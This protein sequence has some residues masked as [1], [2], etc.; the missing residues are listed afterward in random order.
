M[1]ED[2][3]EEDNGVNLNKRVKRRGQNKTRLRNSQPGAGS[4]KSRPHSGSGDN[5]Y[6]DSGSFT[7]VAA[8]PDSFLDTGAP[9]KLC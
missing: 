6:A 8:A 5:E 4:R 1:N 9:G 2:Y 7:G 3:S